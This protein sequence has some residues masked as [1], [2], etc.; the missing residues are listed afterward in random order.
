MDMLLV[1]VL[2]MAIG[3]SFFTYCQEGWTPLYAWFY[4][5][6]VGLGVGYGELKIDHN[7]TKYFT[8][9]FALAGTSII[10]GGLS[11]FYD[12][13]TM[14]I[15]SR[16]LGGGPSN[17]VCMP[18]IGIISRSD[19]KL[20]MMG[21][22]Y[23]V[24]LAAGCLVG[25]YF[26]GY[27]DFADMLLFAVTNYTTA[28]LLTP[29]DNEY[30]LIFTSITLTIG[31]A[32]NGVF[33]GELTSSYFNRFLREAEEQEG[34]DSDDDDEPGSS[35]LDDYGVY[36]ESELLRAGMVTRTNLDSLKAKFNAQDG[37]GDEGSVPAHAHVNIGSARRPSLHT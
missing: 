18:L 11:L 6:N 22:S 26:E 32:I 30:S 21:L 1:Y 23:F 28:G 20:A 31:I 12:L 35:K 4:A 10:A 34:G 19:A 3:I 16:T 2:W 29:K 36:L 25:K 37:T 14:R 33:W 15:K 9:A 8:C 27:T 5:T 17:S 24:M 7:S 13:L